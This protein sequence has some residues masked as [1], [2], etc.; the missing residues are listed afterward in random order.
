[1]SLPPYII[2]SL[3]AL[4]QIDEDHQQYFCSIFNPED[5][6]DGN[7]FPTRLEFALSENHLLYWGLEGSAIRRSFKLKAEME[8]N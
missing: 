7:P 5:A 3:E 2:E 6:I 4:D 1:M 8:S